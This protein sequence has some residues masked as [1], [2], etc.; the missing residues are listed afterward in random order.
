MMPS[1]SMMPLPSSR[2]SLKNDRPLPNTVPSLTIM[3]SET[4]IPLVIIEV[5]SLTE[6]Q[7]SVTPSFSRYPRLYGFWYLLM[8]S[9]PLDVV[10]FKIIPCD[11]LKVVPPIVDEGFGRALD[12]SRPVPRAVVEE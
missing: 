4:I 6:F 12:V 2:S 9:V 10:W 11:Q 7:L 5:L 1:L 8:R 3:P